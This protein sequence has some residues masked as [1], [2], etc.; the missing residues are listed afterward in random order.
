MS[1]GSK[2]GDTAVAAFRQLCH[3]LSLSRTGKVQ[4][5]VDNLVL[6]M[7]DLDPAVGQGG[8]PN[9]VA[10]AV[11]VYFGIAVD[12]GDVRLAIENNLKAGHI[13]IDR[14][15]EPPCIALAPQTKAEVSVRVEQSSQLE[16]SVRLEWEQICAAQCPSIS[17]EVLWSALQQY[18]GEVFR[19]HG[20]EAVQLLD[21]SAKSTGDRGNLLSLLNKALTSVG[22]RTDVE[23]ARTA[24]RGFFLSPSPQRLQYLS[25]LLDGTFTFFALTVS[26][27]TAEYLKEQVPSL[28]L[29]LDTNVVLGV[30]GLQDNPL[31]EACLEVMSVI[32]IERYPFQFYVHERTFKEIVEILDA[33]QSNLRR[34]HY[35]SSL[36]RAYLQM[37][38]ARGIGFGL[39]RKF[40][41]LNAEG[42]IDVD[43]F[44]AR[45]SHVEELLKAEGVKRYNQSGADLDVEVKGEYIAEF[46]H[47]LK[48]RARPG[49][50]PRR[51]T[52]LDHD[53]TVWLYM[54]RQRS[55]AKNALHTGALLLSNDY[56]LHSFDRA[57]LMSRKEGLRAPTVV[58]PHHLLQ[59]LRPLGSVTTQYDARFMAVFAAPEFRT[60]QSDYGITA[61]KVL[62]YL[63]SFQGVPTDTAVHILNDDLLMGKLKDAE[64][65]EDRFAELVDSAIVDENALLHE[66][67]AQVE[68]NLADVQAAEV[69]RM[70]E[71]DEAKREAEV[72]DRALETAR[73][74][75]QRQADARKAAEN[76]A[77]AALLAQTKAEIDLTS[78]RDEAAATDARLTRSLRRLRVVLALILF[79]VCGA[80]VVAG[81]DMFEWT[82]FLH[83]EHHR[84]YQALGVCVVGGLAYQLSSLPHRV[85]VLI[86]IAGAAL[87]AG[88]A[89]L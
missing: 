4:S 42:E 1:N 52:A 49:R 72:R 83:A 39:E 22:I 5:A 15:Q 77:A 35:T 78:A 32:K 41:Q 59:I 79:V 44:L 14:G 37:A 58:L 31:Q 8:D 3:M 19:Q 40:H 13:W 43:A 47:F 86:G 23:A 28:R 12:V 70:Q 30:L 88:L 81:P 85:E 56:S 89:L 6:T 80:G 61:T 34:A 48:Q 71:A 55:S 62:S 75:E 36:S 17:K 10:T 67:L 50:P 9:E 33:A 46:E 84:A 24:I 87:I 69:Q 74:H 53:V 21:A 27:A 66:R 64:Q 82:A 73:V 18:L 26:D 45:F 20:A 54:Q 16:A 76:A 38:E 29:F 51:Y 11:S 63:A 2:A 65:N 60:T 7:L 57:F 25:E 68:R